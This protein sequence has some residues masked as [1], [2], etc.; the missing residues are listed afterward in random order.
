MLCSTVHVNASSPYDVLIAGG[1]LGKIGSLI[2]SAL[3]P[4][5]RQV[6]I[7]CDENVGALFFDKVSSAL[8]SNGIE[9]FRVDVPC[10]E[11]AKRLSVIERIYDALASHSV[12]RSD[13]LIALGGGAAGDAAGFAAAT[14]LRGIRLVQAPTT[15]LA[16]IDSSIGGKTAVDCDFGKNLVGA[17]HQPSLVVSDTDAL[18]SLDARNIRSG[19]GEAVKYGCIADPALFDSLSDVKDINKLVSECAA[20]KARY[21]EADERDMGVRRELN[22]GH[23][24]G[25]A[26]EAAS[27]FELLHGEAVAIGMTAAAR[28]GEKLG[29]TERGTSERI[30]R[31][32]I[33]T[34]LDPSV[35]YRSEAKSY[36]AH[37][38]KYS[39]GYVDMVFLERIGSAVIK[40]V[41]VETIITEVL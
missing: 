30:E 3:D 26:V 18:S 16:Q 8:N 24:I 28:L 14:Y 31:L 7:V 5:P 17:F 33:N 20:I 13:A 2:K 15:L 6:G 37:D 4:L 39:N 34:G 29:I 27:G 32:L 38:K 10:G 11:Y 1:L 9:A 12:S 19:L 41:S 25:H 21:V 40:R 36:I 22:F 35:K 23:T